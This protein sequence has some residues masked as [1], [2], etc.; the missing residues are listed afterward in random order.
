MSKPDKIKKVNKLPK[1]NITIDD[2]LQFDD[3]NAV[4]DYLVERKTEIEDICCVVQLANGS[5]E[6]KAT[7]MSLATAVAML[8]MAKALLIQKEWFEG[9]E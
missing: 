8:E 1:R 4:L 5:L 3:V 2:L 9:E 6:V 7:N